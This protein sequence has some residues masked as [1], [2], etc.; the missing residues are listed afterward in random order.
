[1]HWMTGKS[2]LER[3]CVK[4][5]DPMMTSVAV[6]RCIEKS[7]KLSSTKASFVSQPYAFDVEDTFA[8]IVEAKQLNS[9]GNLIYN[10]KQ[11]LHTIS[12]AQSYVGQ[13][14][15]WQK[16]QFDWAVPTHKEKINNLWESLHP[17]YN[18]GD[19]RIWS[20]IGFQGLD[21]ASDFRGMGML[22]L[23][24]LSYFASNWNEHALKVRRDK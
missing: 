5:F 23:I 14:K 16:T 4:K 11:A 15:E 7:K 2:E 8:A 20:N 3:I 24:Q 10:L 1:M 17:D 22:G 9:K 19:D 6:S 13:L 18:R 21:P 12:N